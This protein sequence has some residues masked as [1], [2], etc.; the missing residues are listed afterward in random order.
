MHK[1]VVRFDCFPWSKC[2]SL[3]GIKKEVVRVGGQV[4]HRDARNCL[5]ATVMHVMP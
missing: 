1:I 3:R 2:E 5:A 4:A